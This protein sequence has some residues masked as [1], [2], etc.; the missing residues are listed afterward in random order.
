MKKLFSSY[1]TITRDQFEALIQ[2]FVRVSAQHMQSK[3][4]LDKPTE[5]RKLLMAGD[6]GLF[7]LIGESEISSLFVPFTRKKI[8]GFDGKIIVI[9]DVHGDFQAVEAVINELGDH[10]Y[11]DQ[12]GQVRSDITLVF[13]GD[14]S[15]RGTASVP[16][17]AALMHLFINNPDNVVL[18]RGNHEY[19]LTNKLFDKRHMSRKGTED[20]YLDEC[21]FL[22]ELQLRFENYTYPDLLYWYDY[23]PQALFL[24]WRDQASGKQKYIQFCHGGIEIGYNP[25]ALLHVGGEVEYEE[26]L[27]FDRGKA[28]QA[29]TDDNIMGKE[30]AQRMRVVLGYIQSTATN[31][32]ESLYAPD[33]LI[34][35][36]QPQ[37]SYHLRF[38]LQWN[39]FLS[40]HNDAIVCAASTKRKNLIFGSL[41]TRYF[42]GLAS[43]RET[44]LCGIIRGHQH[45]NEVIE[46]LGLRGTM[47]DDTRSGNGMVRQWGG[48][49]CTLAGSNSISG[50]QSFIVIL[51]Q[52]QTVRHY[53][54]RPEQDDFSFTMHHLPA[55]L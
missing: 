51:P 18:L 54:K 42:M 17:V 35:F 38:G 14:Y 12:N 44:E 32:F 9:G 6:Q 47:L 48:L 29:L 25:H 50:Y 2:D 37:S 21:S 55:A 7:H 45:L 26:I 46:E 34:D 41:L 16:L 39:N 24:G 40:E 28:L 27:A 13:L 53:Y 10:G 36:T 1:S 23:L 19:A 3:M 22:E 52:Y 11:I 5:R 33:A 4:W 8:I 31:G 20:E 30:I 49:V 15:N 43:S